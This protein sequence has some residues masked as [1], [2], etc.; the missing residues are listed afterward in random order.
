[1]TTYALILNYNTAN[2]TINLYKQLKD[3]HKNE[4]TVLIIDNCSKKED[5]L[6]LQR[7]VSEGELIVI[8]KNLGYAGGNN[9]GIERALENNADFVWILNPDIR[10]ER[11]TLPILL[12]TIQ[13]NERLAAVGPRILKRNKRNEIFSD[14][15][16]VLMNEKCSTIH[17]HSNTISSDYTPE[18]DY[19][20]S[21]IDGCCIL[22]NC[23]AISEVGKLPEEYFLYFEETDW[24]MQAFKKDYE[25]AVNSHALAFCGNSDKGKIYNYYTTRNRLLFSKKFHLNYKEV[26]KYYGKSLLNEILNRF[27]GKYLSPFFKSKLRGYLAG[28]FITSLK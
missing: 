12:K 10:L 22:I 7:N 4:L 9:I 17:K 8:K 15:G 5:V 11:E 20:I 6:K 27:R 23:K 3:F 26:R 16:I 14:G 25:L 13:A 28:I 19:K 2:E 1:M 21:Y 18:L 24:C